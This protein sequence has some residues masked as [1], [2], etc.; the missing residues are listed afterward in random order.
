MIKISQ[1]F[2]MLRIVTVFVL[3]V[4]FSTSLRLDAPKLS[5]PLAA[6]E[7]PV[8]FSSRRS[9]FSAATIAAVA[10]ASSN[11]EKAEAG[12]FPWQ[13]EETVATYQDFK[14]MLASDDIAAVEFGNDGSSLSCLDKNGKGFILRDLPDDP[15]LLKQLYKK[16]VVVT[17][18]EMKF[19]K[20]MN[21]VTWFRDLAGFGDDIT[22]EEM[23]TYRGYKTYRQNIPERAYVPSNLITGYDLSRN[24]RK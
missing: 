12:M 23:Y 16:K 17:L 19:E 20:K 11:P 7:S 8:G 10:V 9:F 15:P 3:L 2:N 24:M 22:E 5:K 21:T 4:T 13:K 14:S 1:L 6:N 18:Q